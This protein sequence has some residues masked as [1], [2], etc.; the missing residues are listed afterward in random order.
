MATVTERENYGLVKNMTGM[1]TTVTHVV[2]QAEVPT[3]TVVE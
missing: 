3:G 2:A 1:F